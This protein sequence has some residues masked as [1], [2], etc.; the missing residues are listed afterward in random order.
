[1][2]ALTNLSSLS[3][4]F[5]VVCVLSGVSLAGLIHAVIEASIF[6]LVLDGL[7]CGLSFLAL[8]WLIFA[9]RSLNK[10]IVALDRMAQGD[11]GVRVLGVRGRG[12]IGRLL[13]NVNRTLDLTEDF[14]NEAD[15]AMAASA[16]G[17]Y[18][19]KILPRGL[20]G[21]FGRHATSI[22]KTVDVMGRQADELATFSRRMLED[23]VG[24]SIAV[25]EGAIA[26]AR[27]GAGI[28]ISRVQAENMAVATEEMVAGIREMA[29][30]SENVVSLSQSAHALTAESR[31]AVD[32][33]I[34][35]F[36][37]VERTVG[38]AARQVRV[39]AEASD[40]IGAILASIQQI[41]HQTNLLALNATIEAARAGEMGKGF[42]VVAGEVKALSNQTAGAAADIGARIEALRTEMTAIVETITRGTEAIARGRDT[43]GAMGQRMGEMDTL[44]GD[45]TGRITE[46][47]RVL[48]Q[49]ATATSLMSQGIETVSQQISSNADA[50]EHS[51]QA[52]Q[53]VGE[54]MKALL[55]LLS[56]RPI[57]DNILMMAK[58]DHVSWKR[59]LAL[60]LLGQE[61]V[62]DLNDLR[63][64][65]TCRLGQWIH[66]EGSLPYRNAPAFAAL[67]DPHH[68]VHHCGIEAIKAFKAGN[69]DQAMASFEQVKTASHEVLALLDQL[70]GGT[71]RGASR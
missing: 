43:M 6:D 53:G 30:R 35:E 12:N 62:P 42:A 37:A 28:K 34:G 51:S 23:A 26:N 60:V 65:T 9:R 36:G 19:R 41:A 39:L 58:V 31:G 67:S 50:I 63:D 66:G 46:M 17:V 48:I 49:Q 32:A 33:A 64:E 61:A 29:E 40:A 5:L 1:M 56:T 8:Y 27:V 13:H 18:Y 54:S 25:H 4:A 10:A 45:V 68:R 11:L 55:A 59:Y 71:G 7:L 22:N 44:V 21:Q 15:A 14:A 20:R 47:S 57:P 3:K 70:R 16:R 24:V 2:R 69:A 52:L 38:D